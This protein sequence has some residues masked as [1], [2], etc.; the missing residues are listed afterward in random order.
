MYVR[1]MGDHRVARLMMKGSWANK[2]MYL[3]D[4]NLSAF[5]HASCTPMMSDNYYM[6]LHVNVQCKCVHVNAVRVTV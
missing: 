1:G 2:C 4:S 6:Y 5:D 3:L